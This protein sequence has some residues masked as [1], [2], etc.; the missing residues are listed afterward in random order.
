MPATTSE[1][2]GVILLAGDPLIGTWTGI[3]QTGISTEAVCVS[4]E[5]YGSHLQVSKG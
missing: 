2:L 4:G 3:Q 5:K 1:G